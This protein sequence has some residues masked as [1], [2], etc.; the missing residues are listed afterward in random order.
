MLISDII[1]RDFDYSVS[2]KNTTL[3]FITSHLSFE[4]IMVS[5]TQISFQC[6]SQKFIGHIKQH[7]MTTSPLAY[8]INGIQDFVICGIK[9][10][11]I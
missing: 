5:T 10:P 11:G 1:G 3:I 6:K 4:Y 2:H 7:F 8:V 9:V